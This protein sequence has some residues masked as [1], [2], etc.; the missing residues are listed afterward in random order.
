MGFK[1]KPRGPKEARKQG[2]PWV[3]DSSPGR[4][5]GGIGLGSPRVSSRSQPLL[6]QLPLLGN[7]GQTLLPTSGCE[8]CLTPG[9]LPTGAS[10]PTRKDL[11]PPPTPHLYLIGRPRTATDSPAGAE[12]SKA[13]SGSSQ[14]A[15]VGVPRPPSSRGEGSRRWRGLSGPQD[16]CFIQE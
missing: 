16:F 8:A 9:P 14:A 3:P 5:E 2:S 13:Q 4:L 11:E 10:L 12:R 1:A 6:C 7:L 15:E